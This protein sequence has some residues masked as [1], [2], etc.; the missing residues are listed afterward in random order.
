[1]TKR[2]PKLQTGQP[3]RID[4]HV[5]DAQGSMHGERAHVVGDNHTMRHQDGHDQTLVQTKDGV[6]VAVPT[7][8]LRPE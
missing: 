6:V 7:K 2:A 3:V 8:A 4:G 1:M 5:G